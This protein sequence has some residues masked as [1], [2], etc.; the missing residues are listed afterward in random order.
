MVSSSTKLEWMG[1]IEDGHVRL[2]SISDEFADEFTRTFQKGN[3][4][5]AL[6]FGVICFVGF[7]DDNRST[8]VEGIRPYASSNNIIGQVYEELSEFI[9]FEEKLKMFPGEVGWSRSRGIGACEK[10]VTQLE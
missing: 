9:I 1:K 2:Q 5:V 3:R 7:G 4:P 10:C 6:G 8:L